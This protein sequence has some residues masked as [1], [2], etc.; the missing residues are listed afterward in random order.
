MAGWHALLLTGTAAVVRAFVAAF[1]AGRDEPGRAVLG[2]DVAFET[3]SLG[4]RLKELLGGA[5]HHVVF[6][7]EPLASALARAV[8]ELGGRVGLGLERSQPVGSASFPFR[9]EAFSR[10]VARE[11]RAAVVGSPPAGV[12]VEGFSEHEEEHPEAAGPEPYAPLHA[13]VYR[14]TGRVAGS[15]PAVLEVRRRA[16]EQAGVEIGSLAV[17]GIGASG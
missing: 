8:Q 17:E 1:A 6:A 11:A 7:P 13:Y 4:E 10:D 16:L 3:A 2:D 14:A 5:G 12:R 15:L 9:V